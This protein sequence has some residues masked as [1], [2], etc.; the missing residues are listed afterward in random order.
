MADE[1]ADAP[2]GKARGNAPAG[3]APERRAER[4]QDRSRDRERDASGPDEPVLVDKTWVYHTCWTG[5]WLYTKLYHRLRVEGYENIPK[6]GGAVLASNHQS[7]LDILTIA[8]SNRRH[9]AFVARDTLA[10]WKW[11][12]FT[13]RGCGAILIQRN[14][15]DRKALRA[16]AQHLER[17]DLVVIFPEGTRTQ[18][19]ALGEF[20]GGALLAARMAKVPIVPVGTRGA[21]EAWPRSRPI[22]FPKQIAVRFGAPIDSAAPDAQARLVVA[23]QSMIGDGRYGSVP[24]TR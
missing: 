5:A 20:K 17:G 15:S 9:V 19:G 11:L 18:D 16:M 23:V 6:E 14:S 12:A 7:H 21:I 8:S 2:V 13:M 22:P 10:H 3:A 4:E 24:P 1:A